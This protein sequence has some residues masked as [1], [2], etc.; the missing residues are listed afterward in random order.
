MKVKTEDR[1]GLFKAVV[2]EVEGNL[3]RTALDEVYSHLRKNVEIQGFRRG[4]APLWL[5]KA[6]YKDYIREEVGK[7]VANETLEEALKETKLKPVADVFLEKV[8]LKEDV[9][10][11]TYTVSFEVPPQ[12]ELKD[13]EGMEVEVP[14]LEFSE[15]LVEK[16]IEQL[17]EEHALWEPVER[18]IKEGDLVTVEYEVEE[19]SREGK[20]EK[21]S[22]ETSGVIGQN[23]FRQELEE[24]LK[25]KKVDEV[26]E[27]ENLPLYDQQGKEIGRANVK[28]KVKEVKEKVLPALDDDF[29]RELGYESWE[30]ARRAI[31]EKVKEDFERMKRSLIEDAV[32]DKLIKEHEMEIPQTLLRRELSFLI[33]RRVRELRNY[34]VDTRYLDYKAM[35]REFTPQAVANIK[36]RYILDR[37]AEKEG[38]EVTEEEVKDQIE[39]LARETGSTPE[40]VREH[41]ERENL[42]EVIRSD[43]LR[44]KALRDIVRKVKI[45]EV[46][47]KEEKEDEGN[48]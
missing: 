33:E 6:K 11:V 37:Y 9:P 4:N 17:R 39:E 2:V 10:K 20:G 44:K 34:G 31:E 48:S 23:M 47:R 7:K 5:I 38:L 35:A 42:M 21:V 3:V 19:V 30:E 29:A 18:E 22:G 36:L 15:D 14:K 16:R 45:K 27:L 40:E 26:V 25:G 28:V 24:A 46:E 13:V 1:E 43:A 32:A 8:D 12:F 41:F